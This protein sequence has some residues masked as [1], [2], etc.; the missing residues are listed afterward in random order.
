V[1]FLNLLRLIV[2]TDGLACYNLVTGH[3]TECSGLQFA[4]KAVLLI[5]RFFFGDPGKRIAAAETIDG[6]NKR[7]MFNLL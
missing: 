1:I 6:K 4:C 7:Q 5:W 2:N 3:W